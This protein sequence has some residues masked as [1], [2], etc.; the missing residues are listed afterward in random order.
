MLEAFVHIH[1]KEVS[2]PTHM[3]RRAYKIKYQNGCHLK[4]TSQNH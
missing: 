3:D 2:M 4:T 1:V